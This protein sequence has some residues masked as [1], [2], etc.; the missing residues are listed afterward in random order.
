MRSAQMRC[1]LREARQ[2]CVLNQLQG[3]GRAGASHSLNNIGMGLLERIK[4]VRPEFILVSLGWYHGFFCPET[5]MI[6]L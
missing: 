4:L 2:R 1:L 3:V 6:L 5:D